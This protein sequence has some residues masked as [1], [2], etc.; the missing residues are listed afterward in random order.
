MGHHWD[1]HEVESTS[2]R[3]CDTDSTGY[4]EISGWF[5]ELWT[6]VQYRGYTGNSGC[7]SFHS[8]I[9]GKH[10]ALT[11]NASMANIS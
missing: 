7:C 6:R 8:K 9:I 2:R 4:L 3:H 10:L 5:Y 11:L 1:Y